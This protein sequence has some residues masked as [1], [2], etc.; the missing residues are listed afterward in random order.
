MDIIKCFKPYI[1]KRDYK[2][3]IKMAEYEKAYNGLSTD[4]KY[5]KLILFNV[6]QNAIKYN[7]IGGNI[8]VSS[9]I[10]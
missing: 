6:I 5:Y 7:K 4:W 2:I 8:K 1:Q 3:S 9:K 10:S